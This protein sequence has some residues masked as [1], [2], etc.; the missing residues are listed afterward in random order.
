MNN[1][2]ERN[3]IRNYKL[4]SKYLEEYINKYLGL[5]DK[6]EFE[7][8]F[9]DQFIDL[10]DDLFYIEIIVTDDVA[11]YEIFETVNSKNEELTS[12]DLI[13][14]L[15]FMTLKNE[16]KSEV[17][18]CEDSWN[19]SIAN[20]SSI[21]GINFKSFIRYYWVSGFG[22]ST[23]KKLYANF[24]SYI[25]N[26]K[27]FKDSKEVVEFL[28]NFVQNLEDNSKLLRIL[29]NAQDVD[30]IIDKYRTSS[31]DNLKIMKSL[32]SLKYFNVKQCYVLLLSLLRNSIKS[33]DLLQDKKGFLRISK[34]ISEI[35]KHIEVF[36]LKF[37]TLGKGQANKVESDVY[38]KIAIFIENDLIKEQEWTERF[39][40]N[41]RGKNPDAFDKMIV[42]AWTNTVKTKIINELDS[43]LQNESISDI[44]VFEG[45]IR[46]LRYDKGSDYNIIRYILEKINQYIYGQKE[47]D[48]NELL[49]QEHILPQK[50]NKWNMTEREVAD[51]VNSIGNIIILEKEHNEKLGNET[52]FD[53]LNGVNTKGEIYKYE[54]NKI[55]HNIDL[56]K[57]LKKGIPKS[58]KDADW[59]RMQ[60]NKEKI[61]K[62]SKDL[63]KEFNEAL[64]KYLD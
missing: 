60:W 51:Y 1:D 16:G 59:S 21:P 30:G 5:P 2:S 32:K 3:I 52:L 14:N 17:D 29:V 25:N 39:L 4:F 41:P 64:E 54:D 55:S 56:F 8:E 12:S 33:Y 53:K 36:T 34:S 18:K 24:K 11:A 48:F 7:H 49:T 23:D 62:R 61:D 31:R 20:V 26:K 57:K 35:F 47:L 15:I 22:W 44:E 28:K 43:I 40:K 45:S 46:K 19:K 38:S 10:L 13:K 42:T 58:D 37:S 63:A 6:K 27:I 9:I 50:P